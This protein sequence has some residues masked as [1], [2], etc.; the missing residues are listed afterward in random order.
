MFS[1]ILKLF[2]RTEFQSLVK[3]TFAERHNRGFTCWRQFVAM[4]FCQLG[5]PRVPDM[6]TGNVPFSSR[7]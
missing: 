3:R 4:L 5:G 7:L 6:A 1:Q 2:P